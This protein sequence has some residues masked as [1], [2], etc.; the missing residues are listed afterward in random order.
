MVKLP[1]LYAS[2][3]L[4]TVAAGEHA[5]SRVIGVAQ[6]RYIPSLWNMYFPNGP[7]VAEQTIYVRTGVR[8]IPP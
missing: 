8:H 4:Y 6:P 3:S 2:D 7:A 1:V 5:V